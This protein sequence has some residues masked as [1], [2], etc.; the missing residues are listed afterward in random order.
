M[1]LWLALLVCVSAAAERPKLVQ[2]LDVQHLKHGSIRV[3]TGDRVKRGEVI[4]QLGNTGSSSS[5][6]HLH[7]HVADAGS[8]LEAEGQPYVFRSFEVIGAYDAIEAATSGKR[9]SPVSTTRTMEL[10]AANVVIV[11]P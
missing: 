2:S 8:T 4:A 11:W 1:R 7:F 3:K 9:W 6:P 10:P 5:G